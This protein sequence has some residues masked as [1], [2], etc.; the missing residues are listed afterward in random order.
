[1]SS[2]DQTCV[3]GK[4][5]FLT[6]KQQPVY[7]SI[8]AGRKSF[9]LIPNKEKEAIGWEREIRLGNQQVLNKPSGAYT[10]SLVAGI[11]SLIG[12]ILLLILAAAAVFVGSYSYYYYDYTGAFFLGLGIWILICSIVIIVSAT[13]LNSNPL[14]YTKWGAI[15][16]V[17]SIIMGGNVFGIIGGILAL[18]FKPQFAM[19]QQQQY[20][21]PQQGPRG[22]T[23]I[24]TQCGRVIDDNV[25]F[26]PHC[27]KQLS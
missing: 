1:L 3:L 14:E 2:L 9:I 23:R 10:L 12:A 20:G 21:F 22:I 13:K 8:F 16:L 17:F 27:G 7:C 26:C 6:E 5:S 19:P 4:N 18:V 24:C 11:L 25:K 15:I